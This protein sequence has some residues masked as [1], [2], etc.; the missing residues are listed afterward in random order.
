M[1]EAWNKPQRAD[2]FGPACNKPG[3]GRSSHNPRLPLPFSLE[4]IV[5]GF[6]SGKNRKTK[7]IWWV[8]TTVTNYYG[9]GYHAAPLAVCRHG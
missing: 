5:A 8:F 7:L 3:A 1:E 2:S 6:P 4:L 9:L